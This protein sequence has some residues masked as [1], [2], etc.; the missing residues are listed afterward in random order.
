MP[1]ETLVAPVA[2]ETAAGT[3]AE[4]QTPVS[5]PDDGADDSI[6]VAELLGKSSKQQ[7]ESGEDGATES[8]AS[9]EEAAP[10]PNTDHKDKSKPT[11]TLPDQAAIDRA[12]GARLAAERKKNQADLDL[13]REL[14]TLYAGK[15]HEDIVK[16]LTERRAEEMGVTPEVMAYMKGA[17]AVPDQRDQEPEQQEQS[18]GGMTTD[19]LVAH[20]IAETPALKAQYPDFDAMVFIRDNPDAVALMRSGVTLDKAYKL[21]NLDKILAKATETAKAAGEREAADR[22]RNRNSRV[23]TSSKGSSGTM[24]PLNPADLTDEEM[25]KIDAQVKAGKRVVL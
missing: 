14:K 12:I 19:A 22:I 8:D 20:V 13:A 1:D 4:V 10:I 5:P 7:A 18:A 6:S 17:R 25:D 16:D 24:G 9:G 15:S 21:T 11:P 2:E 3:D 23:P